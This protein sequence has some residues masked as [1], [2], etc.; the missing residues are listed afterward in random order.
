MRY[1]AR[2]SGLLSGV[3]AAVVAGAVAATDVAPFADDAGNINGKWQPFSF[4]KV[5][6]PSRYKIIL[7]SANGAVL[8]A[9]AERGASA[10]R[11]ALNQS[12][13]DAPSLKFSW[14]VGLLP[15]GTN[16]REKSG[17]D[18]A[19]RLYVT[20]AYDPQKVSALTRVEYGLAKSLHGAYPPHSALN[21][22]VEPNLPE[23]T[24]IANPFTS[25]VKM[26]VVDNGKRLGEWRSFERNIV[27]DYIKAFGVP[28]PTNLSGIVVM[29]DAD[30]TGTRAEA[31][32]GA[33]SLTK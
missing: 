25:R 1:A 31:A 33:I 27:A 29:T 15:T 22:I 4:A 20:F 2:C 8:Q 28:P 21:Y 5:E 17:D 12:A 3:V 10:L 32:Y 6:T 24:I 9:T 23:G 16:A 13:T 30:N 11:F 18:Y 19:A 7:D 14:R 26:I